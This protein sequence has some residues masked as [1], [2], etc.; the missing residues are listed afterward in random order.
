MKK[1]R[2]FSMLSAIALLVAGGCSDDTLKTVANGEGNNVEKE[3]GVYMT[4]NF[5]LPTAK[6][7]RSFTNGD[8]SSSGGTEVAKDYETNVGSVAVVLARKNDNGYIASSLYSGDV[9]ESVGTSGRSFKTTSTFS[10]TEL[11]ELYED[12]EYK[13]IE[14]NLDKNGNYQVNVFVFCNPTADLLNGWTSQVDEYSFIGL[15]K[16][17]YGDTTWVDACGTYTETKDQNGNGEASIWKPNSFLMAN[18]KIST[19]SLP[20]TLGDWD[21]F[22]TAATA[23]N[24]SGVNN[25]GRPNEIDNYNDGKGNIY[26]ERTAARYDFRDGALDGAYIT[27]NP[28]TTDKTF[29]GC[30]PQTYHVVLDSEEKPLLDI[31]LAKMSLVNMNN[32]Y[33][34]LRRVSNNGMPTLLADHESNGFVLCGNELPWYTNATGTL[35]PTS[36]NYVVDAWANWKNGTPTD[37]FA[38]HFVYP[39]FDENGSMSNVEVAQDRWY[40]SKIE[41]VL[42]GTE[43]NAQTWNGAGNYPTYHIW[44]YL[45]EGT[46]PAEPENQQNGISNGV[47]FKGRLQPARE[48]NDDDNEFTRMLLETTIPEQT[49]G[50]PTED[51]ILYVFSNHVYCTWDNIRRQAIALAI[52]KIDKDAEGKWV[53]TANRTSAL[54]HAVFGNGG[55]GT[56]NFSYN[57]AENKVNFFD[58]KGTESITD[59]QQQADGTQKDPTN[60]EELIPAC[61]NY[62]YDQWHSEDVEDVTFTT[63]RE[64]AVKNNIALYQKSYDPDLGGWSYYCYYY[65]WNRHNDNGQPGEMGPMEFDVVRNNVYKL[66]VTKI[67]R[68]GHPRNPDNDP[69]KPNP[70]TPDEKDDLYITVTCTSLPWV[71]RVNDIEF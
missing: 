48:A 63:F 53:W 31:Y 42:K 33:Y 25:L 45:T 13:T 38:S 12:E 65:Y 43:D 7:T 64:A 10:K 70:N 14:D 32:R 22:A 66:A 41:D 44:R 5:E 57:E 23:F 4:I 2:I 54:Y 9:L 68:L 8:N 59:D 39:F 40:T 49:E 20:P 46:I 15:K 50:N 58:T 62:L 3:P 29:N 18:S 26:V 17:K 52:T 11:A 51:P 36:G 1:N 47:V 35:A 19:R 71:V 37:G 6:E 27:P 34:Y 30:A 55:F 56:I 28:Q 16:L 21:G 67:A 60:P 69:D 24:L 61:P